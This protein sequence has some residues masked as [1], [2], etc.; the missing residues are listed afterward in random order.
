MA[1]LGKFV[2]DVRGWVNREFSHHFLAGKM[3]EV[4][5][6]DPAGILWVVGFVVLMVSGVLWLL[7]APILR[8]I[9]VASLR[10]LY[11]EAQRAGFT[12]GMGTWAYGS[13]LLVCLMWFAATSYLNALAAVT[14][15]WRT[16][17]IVILDLDG[18]PTAAKTLPDVGHD[19]FR[20]TVEWWSS[21]E[22]AEFDYVA[23][24]D[25]PDKFIAIVGS[26][27][28][29]F[30]F[31]HPQR[32]LILRRMMAIFGFINLLRAICVACTSL[33]D[34]SPRCISQF[35]DPQRGAYKRRS[36]FPKAY[37]RAWKLLTAPSSHISCGDMVFSGHTVLLVM[38][39]MIFDTYCTKREC[40]TPLIRDYLSMRFLTVLKLVIYTLAGAG[41]FSII[42]TR[43]HYSLDVL[44]A[45]F[46]TW[47]SWSGYHNRTMMIPFADRITPRMYEG[48]GFYWTIKWLEA[49][50]V[51]KIDTFGYQKARTRATSVD[52]ET[53]TESADLAS[54]N[55]A[56]AY[57]SPRNRSSSAPIKLVPTFSLERT[58]S[59]RSSPGRSSPGRS[60]P[61]R[62]S[63]RRGRA[64]GD[65]LK[66]G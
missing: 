41:I 13:R 11:N 50:A 10:P 3:R 55:I 51:T 20:H 64:T 47:R 25:L 4:S 57:S 65:K 5:G 7:R 12:S 42:G 39:A 61:G 15:G 62:S 24:F 1:A 66:K 36:I 26:A 29:L 60:S 49:D 40:D 6:L 44:I 14:A 19:I 58:G 33:P 48:C 18:Q 46:L 17:N 32:L 56:S 37:G 35:G 45:V 54:Y 31:A 8:A 23:W 43:L 53:G 34:A 59:G 52:F 27:T 38:C 28:T 30:I 2:G 63:P 16:P 22:G 9:R 21:E